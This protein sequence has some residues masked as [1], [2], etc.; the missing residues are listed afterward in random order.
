MSFETT[1]VFATILASKGLG[2]SKN[3]DMKSK[4]HKLREWQLTRER[5]CI[6][7]RFPPRSKRPERNIGAILAEIQE[8]KPDFS[9]LPELLKSRWAIIAGE[10][11]AKHTYP[12]TLRGRQL[13]VYAD[14]P[15]WLTE[16]RRLPT[17]HLLK[18]IS[19]VPELPE[20]REIRFQLDPN[21]RTYRN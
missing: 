14:H 10:Q 1:R 19:K 12:V 5:F 9:P 2:N 13:I 16:I 7:S 3:Y 15:G 17:Q 4:N 18:K 20:I 6:S 21:I 8:E 11:I